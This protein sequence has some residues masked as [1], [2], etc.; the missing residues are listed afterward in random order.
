LLKTRAAVLTQLPVVV[1]NPAGP[2]RLR[3]LP[4]QR[5]ILVSAN[6]EPIAEPN[7]LAAVAYLPAE[8]RALFLQVHVLFKFLHQLA[9]RLNKMRRPKFKN[10]K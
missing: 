3:L 7:A 1:L 4:I 10:L 9:L 8:G 2:L 5:L 6:T